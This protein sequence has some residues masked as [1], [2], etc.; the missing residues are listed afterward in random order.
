MITAVE[1]ITL[2][3]VMQAPATVDEDPRGGFVHGGWAVPFMDEVAM[4]VA[5]TGMSGAGA[6]LLGRR[7]VR[8]R[9]ECEAET[10]RRI[11]RHSVDIASDD[12]AEQIGVDARASNSRDGPRS[13]SGCQREQGSGSSAPSTTYT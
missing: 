12:G 9:R 4:R 5:A 3:G 10:Q 7:I 8:Q 6:M 13:P 1:N 11:G 2:D